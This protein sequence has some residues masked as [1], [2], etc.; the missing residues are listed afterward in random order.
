MR[1]GKW[2][3]ALAAI[4]CVAM[5][6]IA[7]ADDADQRTAEVLRAL[8]AGKFSDAESNFDPSAKVALPPEKLDSEWKRMTSELG[9]LKSFEITMR[10]PAGGAQIRIARL[11]FEDT[12][13]WVAQVVVNSSGLVS[14]LLFSP[15]NVEQASADAQKSADER[16]NQFL[17]AIRAA[18]FADAEQRFDETMKS[19][20]PP[21]ALEKNWKQQTASFGTLKRWRIVDRSNVLGGIQVR[22]VNLDFASKPN[23]LALKIE[24]DPSGAI[25]GLFFI[26]PVPSA[27][28]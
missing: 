3:I 7:R 8:Q 10:V 25:G 12:S 11:H 14:G 1:T 22:I 15:S 24:V 16:T 17:E 26:E 21:S 28:H 27:A 13:S 19:K 20:F 6:S 4:L 18:K 23:A 9:Q 5:S 2:A